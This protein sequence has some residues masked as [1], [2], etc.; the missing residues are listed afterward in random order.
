MTISISLVLTRSR[1]PNWTI[2]FA[3]L[4]MKPTTNKKEEKA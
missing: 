4:T 1:Q 2:K 3:L